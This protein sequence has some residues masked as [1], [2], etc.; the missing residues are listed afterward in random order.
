[1]AVSCSR[2]KAHCAVSVRTGNDHLGR[3]RFERRRSGISLQLC[4]VLDVEPDNDRVVDSRSVEHDVAVRRRASV[5]TANI[6]LR[7]LNESLALCCS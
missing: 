1:M 3:P 4:A 7:L 2:H 5:C 6:D